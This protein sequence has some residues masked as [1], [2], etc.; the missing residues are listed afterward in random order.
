MNREQ[1]DCYLDGVELML[2]ETMSVAQFKA[3]VEKFDQVL[4]TEIA[5]AKEI[6]TVNVVAPAI[7]VES[8][9]DEYQWAEV[10]VAAPVVSAIDEAVNAAQPIK[11]SVVI[12]ATHM[13]DADFAAL[14]ARIDPVIDQPASTEQANPVG[15]RA[16]SI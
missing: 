16:F 9:P 4:N 13:S 14:N 7:D 6:A 1:F 2:R 5:H 15:E 8:R 12:D 10:R 3:I 11:I